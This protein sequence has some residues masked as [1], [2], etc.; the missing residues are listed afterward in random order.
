[1]IWFSGYEEKNFN[2]QNM[3]NVI[4]NL[5]I[6]NLNQYINDPNS[7]VE[8]RGLIHRSQ[9]TSDNPQHN[10]WI[11][12]MVTDQTGYPVPEL[13]SIHVFL[14]YR[15]IN[16]SHNGATYSNQ[17]Y[18]GECIKPEPLNGGDY[19]DVSKYF[20]N[21]EAISWSNGPSSKIDPNYKKA[22]NDKLEKM[23][24]KASTNPAALEMIKKM[25]KI[26]AEQKK[27]EKQNKN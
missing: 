13:S 1:M 14:C 4:F 7:Q 6:P 27:K 18:R 20:G 12:V 16:S 21:W 10:Y 22:S 19:P 2:T 26:A 24:K 11:R 25:K 3:M 5:R 23:K 17:Y 9:W 15:L 8:V